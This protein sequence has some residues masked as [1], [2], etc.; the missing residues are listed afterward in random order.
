L[1]ELEKINGFGKAKIK[2]FGQEF[3]DVILRYS[4]FNNLS[5][6]INEK[7][8]KKESKEKTTTN[9]TP[10]VDTKLLSFNLYKE[11]KSI[12]D[13]AAERS[14]TTQTIESHLAHYVSLGE[15]KIDELVSREKIFLIE[16]ALENF[17][18]LS[19]TTLKQKLDNS[20][21]FG[22]IKLVLAWKE[23]EKNKVAD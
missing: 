16:P 20:I 4:K 1:D 19:I 8:P 6:H 5:S 2:K 3:L 13:I 9:K 18:G 11:G 14:L 21:S 10:K 12:E 7:I 17:D 15:I 23:F 22:E